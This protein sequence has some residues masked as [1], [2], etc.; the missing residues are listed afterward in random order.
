MARRDINKSKFDTT[1]SLK[2]DIFRGC[3]REWYPVF[4]H[5][6][7]IK[8]VYVFDLFA[9]SGCDSEGDEGS[10]LIL[11][12]EAKGESR[13]HCSTIIKNKT[14]VHF[15]YNELDKDKSKELEVNLRN[16]L[17]L[18]NMECHLDYCPYKDSLSFHHEEFK[19]LIHNNE[20]QDILNNQ[21]YAKF[22]L[23]DQYGFKEV[24]S[25]IFQL[26][27]NSPVADIV[28]FIAS[29]FVKRFSELPAVLNYFDT[30]KIKWNNDRPKEC[31]Q[32]IKE[33][34]ASLL[35]KDREYYLHAF[36][37]KK[38]SNY[39]GLIFCTAHSLGMEKFIKV[40]WSE[41][42][43]AGESN[44]NVG[45]FLASGS[46][47]KEYESKEVVVRKQLQELVLSGSITSNVDG[48]KQALKLGCRPKVFVE[49][50][51]ELKDQGKIG[52]IGEFNRK[53]TGIHNIDE[54][55][56]VIL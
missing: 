10:P 54:Y 36:T 5:S 34:Y 52:I 13:Q 37:M 9:G 35:P 38:G 44:C 22:V 21:K 16:N 46:L 56:I 14:D 19:T 1:T 17:R 12:N 45:G 49:A 39:Y 33:Y 28:F 55:K 47:F 20:I 32:I 27:I 51:K 43:Q 31:H 15:V 53:A 8:K 3:F 7:Y 6:R 26:L 11:L 25:E 30:K 4:I 42:A 18:C 29:S 48:L 40:C 2:L 24:D 23:L 50:I 41:D